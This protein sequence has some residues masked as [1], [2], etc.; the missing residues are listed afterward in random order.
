MTRGQLIAELLALWEQSAQKLELEPYSKNAV[1]EI[2]TAISV[3]ERTYSGSEL[4]IETKN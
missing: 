3:L 2:R 4:G 1:Q